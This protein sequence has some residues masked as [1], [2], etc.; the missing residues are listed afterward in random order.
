LP[1]R[2]AT[3][4]AAPAMAFPRATGLEAMITAPTTLRAM[5][6]MSRESWVSATGSRTK[7]ETVVLPGTRTTHVSASATVLTPAV[8]GGLMA[9]PLT[10]GVMPETR[11]TRPPATL[12]V[13]VLRSPA[14][15]MVALGSEHR[16]VATPSM[17]AHAVTVTK[18]VMG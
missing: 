2:R 17:V 12:K 5:T 4:A 1:V 16:M 18:P 9:K 11:M 13:P 15:T 14:V 6:P 8:A 3:K 7:P 10:D